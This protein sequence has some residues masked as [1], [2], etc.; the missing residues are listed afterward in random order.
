MF[1]WWKPVTSGEQLRNKARWGQKAL[2][3]T[4][5]EALQY[6]RKNTTNQVT[7][8]ILIRSVKMTNIRSFANTLKFPGLKGMERKLS[9]RLEKGSFFLIASVGKMFVY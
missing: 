1:F 8:S 6:P 7:R 4:V 9:G 2:K 5:L 3:L